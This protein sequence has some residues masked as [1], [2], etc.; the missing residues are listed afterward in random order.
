MKLARLLLLF[1]L[2]SCAPQGGI[3]GQQLWVTP[4]EGGEWDDYTQVDADL[5]FTTIQAAIDAASFG[6]TVNV[7]S[8]T[9]Y[10]N[11]VMADGV[12]VD[13]G[14]QDETRL[15][16]SVYF[17]GLDVSTTLS[18]M[19]LFD[20]I[21]VSKGTSYGTEYGVGIQS[22]SAQIMDVAIYYFEAGIKSAAGDNVYIEGNTLGF[23]WYGTNLS[24]ISNLTVA[25]NLVGNNPAAGI[26]SAYSAGTIMFNTV[27]GNAF[28][29][30]A[31]YLTG[32]I[33]IEGGGSERVVNNII[34]SNYYGLNCYACDGSWDYNLVW[35]N[36]TD[37]VND[38]SDSGSDIAGD[39][40]FV[41]GS[42][43]NFHLTASSP[44]IDAANS[45][46]GIVVDIDGEAR[47]QGDNYDIGYD[48]F[49]VSAFSVLITEVMAN[50][51]TE[52][53]GEFV[54]IY[55]AGSAPLDLAGLMITDGDD[56]DLLQAFDGGTTVVGAGEYAV[57]VDPEYDGV[58]GIDS[59]VTVV[60]TGDTTLGNGLTT[61]DKI[62]LYESDGS[63]V[64]AT[65]SYPSD[66]GDGVS[67]EMY[68]LDNGDAS[69]NWRASQC[70]AES[71]PGTGHCFPES[72]DPADLVITEIM[73]NAVS[74]SSGEYIEIYNPT[75]TDIDLA[76][77]VIGDNVSTDIIEAFQGGSTLLG[78]NQHAVVVDPDYAYDYY[79][80][81]DI[82]LMTTPD[83][84][85]GNGLSNST[86]N[87]YLYAADGSTIID[88]FSFPGDNG[89]GVAWEKVDYAAG[90]LGTNWAAG[91]DSCTRGAS[92]GRLNGAASG[93]CDP[94]IINEVMANA[95][96]E[97]TGE[98][99]EIYNAGWDTVD[100]AGLV[101]TDGDE[102]DTLQSF[103]GSSTELAPGAFALVLDAEYAGEYSI[104]SSVVLMTTS[105]TT[106]GNALSVSDT[107]D[108]Y[109]ADGTHLIDSYLWP[110]NP[111]NAVSIER[112]AMAGALDS[113]ANW[114]AS[115]CAA[116][117]SPGLEN[118]SSAT[119][120]GPTVSDLYGDL[121]ITEVMSNALTESTGEFIELYNSGTADIDLLHYV[122]YDGDAIDTIFGFTDPY[123]T[124]LGAGE[125]AVILD[126]DYAGE[127]TIP[128]GT[129]VLVTD[130]STIGSGLA[131]NDPIY[132]YEDNAVSF[133][134]SYTFPFNAGNGISVERVDLAV[135]DTADNWAASECGAG[136][137]PGA[138]HCF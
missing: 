8:G 94:L 84:T 69:G 106:I 129:L 89:D 98:F 58:Y 108:L 19:S 49:G 105:D 92:P 51:S 60:T 57:V 31:A 2:A 3:H 63:T 131:T 85:L 66:P 11:L 48:E 137:S 34:T 37:Y 56:D 40:L 55:N 36:S 32:G 125:Y 103:D 75:T 124:I 5:T 18:G 20:P 107:V 80:P 7:P 47:P 43:G 130:D 81:T 133:I 10:E 120:S 53:T 41:A 4:G 1:P 22:G 61:S 77:L 126:A 127:Y 68:N 64:I 116:G 29:G 14:G 71:S 119:A 101:I 45:T 99:V 134:D 24:S 90:D 13:G 109:E 33:A 136:S 42:E 17:D 35:G 52:S 82:V 138:T 104:D 26:A 30:T 95:D 23:N 91:T 115:T 128:S 50:A 28:S 122:V 16:G 12:T 121:L 74:E 88:S 27:I 114:E 123:D 96:D 132:L 113:D 117:S 118:C 54:E 15:V 83:A 59:G 86:D 38:A 93:T 112:I 135:G 39:P 70:A 6:D 100:L 73:A 78:P 76:G 9:Y 62:T 25:N 111:G 65:F 21:W 87:V 44:A 97:D 79:L 67:M 72:G 46:V 110:S 102:V